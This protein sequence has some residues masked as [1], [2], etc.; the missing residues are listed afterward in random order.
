MKI[1]LARIYIVRNGKSVK[2]LITDIVVLVHEVNA[3]SCELV[4][5]NFLANLGLLLWS[6]RN[7]HVFRQVPIHPN[8]KP[9]TRAFAEINISTLHFL[10]LKMDAMLTVE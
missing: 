5:N 3:L 1:S 10:D 2:V 6:S 9:M 7:G 8:S 4:P